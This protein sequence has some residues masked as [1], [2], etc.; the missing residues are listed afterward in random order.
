MLSGELGQA[1]F[2]T[3]THCLEPVPTVQAA[4]EAK[5]KELSRTPGYSAALVEVILS[6]E[7]PVNQRQLAAVSLKNYV[8]KNWSAQAESEKFEGP[9]PPEE[10]KTLVKSQILNGLSDAQT[11]IRGAVAYAISKIAHTDWPEQW[12]DLLNALLSNV[13]SG[14]PNRV[15]GAM[16]VLAE[17]MKNDV[18]DQQFPHVAPILLPELFK[19]FSDVQTYSPQSRARCA[20]VFR[21]AVDMLN[22]VK[23][24]HPE[25]PAQ[26]LLPLMPGWM[27]AFQA[28]L[29]GPSSR[30]TEQL[31]LRLEVTR[32]LVRISHNF[33]KMLDPYLPGLVEPVWA[34]LVRLREEYLAESVVGSTTAAGGEVDSEGEVTGLDNLIYAYFDFIEGASKR[35]VMDPFLIGHGEKRKKGKKAS[36]VTAPIPTQPAALPELVWVVMAYAQITKEQ[37]EAWATDADQYVADEDEESLAFNVR[38][39]AVD[40]LQE[41]LFEVHRTETLQAI[42][43]ASQRHFMEAQALR[44]QGRPHWWKAQEAVLLAIGR[45][46]DEIV[47]AVKEEPRSFDIEGIF[48]QVVLDSMRAQGFPFLQ[49]RAIWFAAKFC[50]VLPQPL[51]AEYLN[52][53]V[54]GIEPSNPNPVRMSAVKAMQ[55]FSEHV[56][57]SLLEPLYPTIVNGISTLASSAGEESLV[58]L[59]ETMYAV[60]SEVGESVA[61]SCESALIEVAVG[62]WM[63]HPGDHLVGAIVFELVSLL[64][65]KPSI[66]ESLQAR[67]LP[68]IQH[69]MQ[70]VSNP[71][72]APGIAAAVDLLTILV[73]NASS[74]LPAGYV[75]QVFPELLRTL[76]GSD[77][78]SIIQNGQESLRWFIH[79]DIQQISLWQDN[80]GTTGIHHLMRVIA[81]LLS[82]SFSESASMFVGDLI[83]KLIVKAGD[84]LAPVFD[85]LLRAI[86]IRLGSAEKPTFI[87]TLVTVFLHLLQ[88]NQSQLVNFL[89]GLDVNGRNGLEL[90]VSLWCENY[91]FFQGFYTL[92]LN[93]VSMCN[94]FAAAA[95][96]ERL[97]QIAVKGDAIP[98]ETGKIVTRSKSKLEKHSIVPF[99]VKA[100]KLLI[101]DFGQNWEETTAKQLVKAALDEDSDDGGEDGGDEDVEDDGEGDDWE[102]VNDSPFVS[103]ENYKYL[104]DLIE[105]GVVDLDSGDDEDDP[106]LK[107]DPVYHIEMREY[108]VSFFKTCQSENVCGFQEIYSQHLGAHERKKLRSLVGA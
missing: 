10:V 100:I 64:A 90:F 65:S 31:I 56:D 95:S 19:I 2:T 1:V 8:D 35:A 59:L 22:N 89:A 108:F 54:A 26:F 70:Q 101:W 38:I 55:A 23:G 43:Q 80:S 24:E 78:P 33:P 46:A 67:L 60:T 3:L 98:D 6:Q 62:V 82:P 87:Q 81:R 75:Q 5:L 4:A 104:S 16:R 76:E 74:P 63:K 58:L 52:A 93:A 40:L 50:E 18:T 32:T 39:A 96:D 85:D 106:D 41:G 79:K 83:T 92:K 88:K 61:K 99:P 25:A 77:D 73:K 12:P 9:E 17:F 44:A 14:D 7:L 84:L 102:D 37:E 20:S 103:A 28:V 15:H 68:A 34:D 27:A 45:L 107:A 72:N 91:M 48:Q 71:N 57:G 86:A 97:R 51:A 30:A 53:A 36:K 49:G 13:Q 42:G 94:L 47:D 21:D 69:A 11:R 105:S 66:Y 29:A